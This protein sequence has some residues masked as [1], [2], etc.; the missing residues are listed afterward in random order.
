MEKELNPE[1]SSIVVTISELVPKLGLFISLIGA[2][3]STALALV[4]PPVI[5]LV[6]A[7]GTSEG[8]SALVLSKNFLILLL[9]LFGLITGTYESLSA[10]IKEFTSGK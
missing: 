7:W 3:C 1:F 4:F 2:L 8:P 5:E 9:A 10:L 6:S